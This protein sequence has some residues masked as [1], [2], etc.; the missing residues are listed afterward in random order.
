MFTHLAGKMGENEVTVLI[1][2]LNSEH[3]VWKGLPNDPFH[4]NSFFFSHYDSSESKHTGSFRSCQ[5]VDVAGPAIL[6]L[7]IRDIAGVFATDENEETTPC[8][9]RGIA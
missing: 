2:K 6:I 3:G 1:I 5:P 9:M 8:F 7:T 4:F